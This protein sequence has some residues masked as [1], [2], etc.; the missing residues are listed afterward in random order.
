MLSKMI[1]AQYRRPSGLLGRWIGS[2]MARDHRAENLWTLSILEAQPT[3]QVL[4][5]GFGPGFA[6][7]ELARVVTQGRIAGV[8]FSGTILAAARRCNAAAIRRG[9]VDLHRADAARLPFEEASFDKAFSIHSIYFWPRP[10]DALKEAWRVLR[11]GAMLILTV[12]PKEKWN[13]DD[14]SAPVGTPQCTPYSG[15][16][17]LDLFSKAGFVRSRIRSDSNPA[18]RSNYSVV[19]IK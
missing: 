1:D 9:L 14:P 17:L 16:E 3:D 11:P 6:V 5:I 7:Q 19:G 13:E 2:R 10:L 15:E 8:D 18:H 4:E 12:L